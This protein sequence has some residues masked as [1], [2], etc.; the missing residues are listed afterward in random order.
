MLHQVQ[1][2]FIFA[3]FEPLPFSF[4]IKLLGIE[5]G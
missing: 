2:S 1:S 4:D 3:L 5:P